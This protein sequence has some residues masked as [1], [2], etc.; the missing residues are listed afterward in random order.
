MHKIIAL[1]SAKPEI[2]RD[3]FI[4]YYESNHAPLIKSLLP[5]ITEYRRNYLFN[6]LVPYSTHE[7][8]F[9]V[10]TELLFNSDETL[11]AFW[12]RLRDPE[13]RKRIHEDE[14]HF[15]QSDKTRMIGVDEFQSQNGVDL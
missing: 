4:D 13:V 7:P 2:S 6:D 9:D 15:L 3:D 11:A 8:D 10:L 14:Q 5:M 12:E 1:I